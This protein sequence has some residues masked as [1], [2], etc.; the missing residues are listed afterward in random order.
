MAEEKPAGTDWERI[1]ADFRAGLLSTREIASA[2]GVS[3]T[4]INK[5]A[6][7]D[8]WTRS[9]ASANG[10]KSV[11]LASAEDRPA[12]GFVYAIYIDAPGE[13]L[14]KIGMAARFCARFDAHQCASPF[15]IGVACAYFV[16]DMRA[17]ERQLH[18]KFAHKRVRG[19]WFRL[20]DDDVR[21]LAT[22]AVLV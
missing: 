11:V 20:S 22:R 2:A 4:A 15:D 12:A 5:R 10:R 8:G 18:A 17:E 7:R 19:E 1:E 21:S 16:G 14:Y 9:S 13:R 6:K 3:H